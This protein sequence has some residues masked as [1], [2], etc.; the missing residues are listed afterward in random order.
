MRAVRTPD[1]DDVVAACAIVARHLPPTPVAACAA[2]GDGVALKLETLQPTGSFK[3]R[4][5][6]VAVATAITEDPTRPLVTASAG[7]H[8]LGVA[9]AATMYGATAT[10]VVPET[11]STAKKAALAAFDV[12]LLE[13]GADYDAAEAHA[14]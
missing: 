5:A 10:I 14:I 8:G 9:F 6:L 12:T 4:G 7:N 3:V 13:H 2:L 11:A 1:V